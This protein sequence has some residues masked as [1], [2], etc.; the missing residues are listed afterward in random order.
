MRIFAIL[1]ATGAMAALGACGEQASVPVAPADKSPAGAAL[2]TVPEVAAP[3]VL[4]TVDVAAAQAL[5]TD[6]ETVEAVNFD[7][8]GSTTVTGSVVGYKTKVYAVPVL[9]GQTLTVT[10]EPVGNTNLYVNVHDVANAT[11]EA[12]H[13]GDM[14]G[15]TASFVAANDGVYLVRPWQFR[16][17]AR[18]DTESAYSIVIERK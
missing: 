12:V 7:L 16:A 17:I 6:D 13:Q 3:A 4:P 15:A 10:L 14:A 1:A 11:G 8:V 2:P 9:A 5:L 18:R